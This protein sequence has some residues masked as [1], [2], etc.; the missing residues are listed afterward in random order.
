MSVWVRPKQPP[1][2][3]AIPFSLG[4]QAGNNDTGKVLG[5]R[6]ELLEILA[7][8]GTAV[9]YTGRCQ[10]TGGAVAVK[11]LYQTAKEAI[12]AFFSQEGRLAARI[13]NPHLVH[14]R[15]FGEDDGRLFIVFDLVPGVALPELYFLELMPWRELFTVVLQV[16]DGLAALHAEGIVHRDVK[17]D[18]V[19]VARTI[20]GGVHVTLLD[21]GFCAVPPARRITGAPEPT[22][23]VYGTDGFIAPELLGG[24]LPDPRNDLYSVGALMYIMLTAQRVPDISAAPDELMIPSPRAF[25]PSLPQA[26]DD[27][28]MRALS[29]VA[30]RFQDAEEMAAEIRDALDADARATIRAALE[31]EPAAGGQ[32]D[33]PGAVRTGLAADSSA[34]AGV[35]GAEEVASSVAP[36]VPEVLPATGMTDREATCSAPGP[37][38]SATAVRADGAEQ[39]TPLAPAR[40]RGGWSIAAAALLGVLGGGTA[41]WAVQHDE[42]PQVPAAVAAVAAAEIVPQSELSIR[43]DGSPPAPASGD[44]ATPDQE[45]GPPKE[46]ASDPQVAPKRATGRRASALLS[47]VAPRTTRPAAPVPRTVE[48]QPGVNFEQVMG[49]L[50]A[51]VRACAAASSGGTSARPATVD[52]QVRFDPANGSI[53]RVRVLKL[54]TSDPFASCVERLVRAAA[55]PAGGNPNRIFTY[56]LEK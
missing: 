37:S 34:V 2:P 45:V 26:V 20:G 28:V 31:T 16:L 49:R 27:I 5:G 7:N 38:A 9:V 33:A 50:A 35:T 22:R 1:D 41:V 19:I 4:E 11:V 56:S 17:P 21:L 15:D 30:A 46:S 44:S 53:D 18:N 40:V 24:A 51:D 48:A 55:P 14:A 52:V 32:V 23:D 8:G 54:G 39:V 13:Q 29:D 10:H 6:Y 43:G 3:N 42:D 12:G 47:A 36:E 25:V